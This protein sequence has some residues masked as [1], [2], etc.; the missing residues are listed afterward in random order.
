MTLQWSDRAKR[1]F[2]ANGGNLNPKYGSLVT[3]EQL[4]EAEDRL[5]GATKDVANGTSKPNWEKHELSYALGTPEHA[6]YNRGKG[7]PWKHDFFL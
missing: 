4:R 3:S 1:Y 2:F 7:V 5:E 6:R